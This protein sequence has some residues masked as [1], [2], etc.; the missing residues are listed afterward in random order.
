MAINIKKARIAR[1]LF[2][3][4][5]FLI[6][7]WLVIWTTRKIT[8][9]NV[10]DTSLK[11]HEDKSFGNVNEKA[12]KNQNHERNKLT[13]PINQTTKHC[14]EELPVSNQRWLRARLEP[15]I[16]PQWTKENQELKIQVY[17]WWL[18]LQRSQGIN[19]IKVLNE[20]FDAGIPTTNPNH[21]RI[22]RTKCITCAVVGNSG[23]LLKSR[24]GKV[25]TNLTEN[26]KKRGFSVS[27]FKMFDSFLTIK[28]NRNRK[29]H[30]YCELTCK[31]CMLQR[32]C[33]KYITPALLVSESKAL[34]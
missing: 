18:T 28:Q 17:E 12:S 7:V 9:Y 20:L 29:S 4:S 31:A 8:Q 34:G 27:V 24:Y 2:V 33:K 6:Y 22:S 13:P 3:F 16:K 5:I 26:L 1:M 14:H 15:K 19:S 23:N 21:Q 30:N 32:P 11:K 10:E 25:S